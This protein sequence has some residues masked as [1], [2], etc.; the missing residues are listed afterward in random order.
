MNAPIKRA[1]SAIFLT[2][3]AV[4][5]AGCSLLTGVPEGEQDVFTLAIG[6][7]IN[8]TDETEITSIPVVDCDEPHDQEV[9]AATD[10]T[11][12]T[13][14]GDSAVSD[15]LDAFCQ[16]DVFTDFIGLAYADSIFYTSGLQ[17]TSSSWDNGD[18][19][20]LCTVGNPDG[21]TTGTLAGI[22]Q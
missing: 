4:S 9:F 7:C 18:R 21:K 1:V 5:L 12:D 20:L 15:E 3:T 13:F 19:E 11:G 2:V 6:D 10:M 14:P 8:T 22:N 16:G 17:P